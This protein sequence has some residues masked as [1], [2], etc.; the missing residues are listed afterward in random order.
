MRNDVVGARAKLPLA[1]RQMVPETV[2]PTVT[3]PLESERTCP[4]ILNCLVPVG[5]TALFLFTLC[6]VTW[7]TVVACCDRDS[8]LQSIVP[9]WVPE[10]MGVAI[11]PAP[12]V[13]SDGLQLNNT[14]GLI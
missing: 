9:V 3:E 11:V 8:A 10:K 5:Q 4:E 13:V 14:E 1:C 2:P 6:V 12:P 7:I